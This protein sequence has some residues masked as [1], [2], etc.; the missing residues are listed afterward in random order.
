MSL[1]VY[2][3]VDCSNK[4]LITHFVWYL[5]KEKRCD[6]KI[7]SIDKVLNKETLM[8]KAC[9]KYAPKASPRLL[10]NFGK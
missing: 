3:I 5:K 8:E 4:N 9:R 2:N 7:L 10:F 6:I 1:K